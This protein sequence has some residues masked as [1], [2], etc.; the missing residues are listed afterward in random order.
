VVTYTT[1]T[2]TH[3]GPFRDIAPTGKVINFRFLDIF[4]L[5]DGKIV[6]RQ[7]LVDTLGLLQ[8]LG[9]IRS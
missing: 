6:E 7:G 3:R 9:A 5:R 4:R 8:Q 2:G 1:A